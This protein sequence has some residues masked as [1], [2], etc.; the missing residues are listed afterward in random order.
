MSKQLT[1]RAKNKRYTQNPDL[2]MQHY[3]Q[4]RASWNRVRQIIIEIESTQRNR[5]SSS[6][7]KNGIR[8]RRQWVT[9][10]KVA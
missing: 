8:V 4:Q 2:G 1:V 7:L 6:E 5:P 10:K 9:E 3:E